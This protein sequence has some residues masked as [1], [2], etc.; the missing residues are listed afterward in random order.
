M[1]PTGHFLDLA[2]A[3]C[4]L[5]PPPLLLPLPGSLSSLLPL[6]FSGRRN[7]SPTRAPGRRAPSPKRDTRRHHATQTQR[8][9]RPAPRLPPVSRAA[10]SRTTPRAPCPCSPARPARAQVAPTLPL[11]AQPPIP[12]D[13]AALRSASARRPGCDQRRAQPTRRSANRPQQ[14]TEAPRRDVRSRVVMELH[15][16]RFSLFPLSIS[17]LPLKWV[18]LH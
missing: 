17:S 15:A 12:R 3:P 7:R 16:G 11:R 14:R 5:W 18:T 8:A 4:S 1:K 6:L 10:P 9:A 2:A 13:P